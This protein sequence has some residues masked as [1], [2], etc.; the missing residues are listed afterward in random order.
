MMDYG[1]SDAE[2]RAVFGY[3]GDECPVCGDECECDYEGPRV[4][5]AFAFADDRIK[6]AK[7]E[8]EHYRSIL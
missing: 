8:P 7:E 4:A 2:E 6:A 3:D 5:A 1:L